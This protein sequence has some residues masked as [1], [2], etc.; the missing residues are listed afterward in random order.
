MKKR[1]V[2]AAAWMAL[3]VA[4]TGCSSGVK[5]VDK[6]EPANEPT[7]W[8]AKADAAQKA[9]A[10]LYWNPKRQMFDNQTPCPFDSCNQ[11]FNYWW[12]AH[13]V[14]TLVDGYV[15]TGD[16]AYKQRLH[17]LYTGLVNRNGGA[18]PNEFY[19]DMEWMALA[20]LRA[21]DAT[22][23]ETY[24]GAVNTL[25]AD[26]Q[27]GW[28]D[29]M[30]GGIAWRKSQLNYKNAPA[31]GP[32]AILAARLYEHFKNTADLQWATKIYAWEKSNLI[33]PKSGFV[34]D[35]MNRQG[36]GAVDSTWAFTYNQGTFI[37][38]GVA[39]YQVTGDKAYLADA[40]RNWQAAKE[41]LVNPVTGNLPD[42]G[43]GDGGLFKGIL[44]RYMGQLILADPS[45]T[46]ALKVLQD[47]ARGLWQSARAKDKVIFNQ[48]WA[49]RPDVAVKLSVNLSGIMLLE[50]MALLEKNGLL[51]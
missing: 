23:D 35:G 45:Q 22:G 6:S 42:E 39:L 3:T 51:K 7:T 49:Q 16:G 1:N 8:A 48:N 38:A 41:R 24:K 12:Q 13:A 29:E 14:D 9:L 33:D 43:D 30:G 26:I 50:Q 11:T 20:W 34:W 32:A 44:V 21:Y 37:G 36:D 25:W 5:A 4:I 10:D 17:D 27:T 18:L 2:M 46:D 15:R 28:N 40:A 47:S 31:N 19:D